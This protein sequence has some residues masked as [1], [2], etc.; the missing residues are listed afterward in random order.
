VPEL[1]AAL[2]APRRRE[3]LRLLWGGE[4]TAGAVHRAMPDVSF[5]AV[6]QHLRVLEAAGL[7]SRR[8]EGRFRLY[9]ARREALGP[10]AGWL[11]AMWDDAL[12]RLKLQAEIEQARRG[13]RSGRR[14]PASRQPRGRGP[15]NRRRRS[16]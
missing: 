10:L 5:G 4:Q 13:P 11:E 6:S 15:R 16:R 1:L 14:R 8:P 7:V 2:A 12:A 9:A 3:I